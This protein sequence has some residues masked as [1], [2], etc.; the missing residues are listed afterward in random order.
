MKKIY[1]ILSLLSFILP[2]CYNSK[3]ETQTVVVGGM[4]LRNEYTAEEII[5]SIKALPE[6]IGDTIKVFRNGMLS[7]SN[8][9]FQG[10]INNVAKNGKEAL[11][12]E[13]IDT[14]I[15]YSILLYKLSAFYY[16][17]QFAEEFQ[18]KAP[19]TDTT[20]KAKANTAASSSNK[21]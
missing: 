6:Y 10:T 9:K 13:S 11:E 3:E 21:K 12:K 1:L 16:R 4:K 8:G 5:A 17:Q 2:A 20:Q 15:P 7:S 19:A 14:E 18:K